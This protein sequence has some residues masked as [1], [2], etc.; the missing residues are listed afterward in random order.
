VNTRDRAGR[1]AVSVESLTTAVR[2]VS[3]V[4]DVRTVLRSVGYGRSR[5]GSVFPSTFYPQEH[6]RY[7]TGGVR[8]PLVLTDYV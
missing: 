1:I 6:R 2:T 5:F 4:S 7:A 3:A 8:F